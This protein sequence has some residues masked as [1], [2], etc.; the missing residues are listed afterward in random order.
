MR[1]IRQSGSEGGETGQPVF[2]TP[3]GGA[4][5]N[6]VKHFTIFEVSST[7]PGRGSSTPRGNTAGYPRVV[8]ARKTCYF[9]RHDTPDIP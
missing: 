4:A 5:G 9:R 6:F 7:R 2:P 8:L 1:E 3:I